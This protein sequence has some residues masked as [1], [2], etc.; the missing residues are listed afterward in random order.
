[1]CR[2]NNC[3]D[4]FQQLLFITGSAYREARPSEQTKCTIRF[5]FFFFLIGRAL[6]HSTTKPH[7]L[8]VYNI[9]N[10]DSRPTKTWLLVWCKF[11]NFIYGSFDYGDIKYRLTVQR[12][13]VTSG[14][15]G[16]GDSGELIRKHRRLVARGRAARVT[17]TRSSAVHVAERVFCPDGPSPRNLPR[18]E[19]TK[20]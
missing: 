10:I 1:M 3:D 15:K 19:Y 8:P 6:F 2:L 13:H 4:I 7:I 18:A 9:N 16:W 20:Y 12:A 11:G 14:R 5:V 17:S